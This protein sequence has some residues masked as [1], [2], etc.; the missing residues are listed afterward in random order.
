MFSIYKMNE[1]FCIRPIKNLNQKL[2][3]IRIA[4]FRE[5]KDAESF[6]TI[7]NFQD[8]KRQVR[9]KAIKAMMKAGFL[10]SEAEEIIYRF[11]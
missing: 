8:D 5:R 4:L 11:A 1:K 6:V 7:M 9:E 2:S 10:K 3:L